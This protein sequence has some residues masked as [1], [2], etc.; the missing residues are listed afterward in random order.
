M[1]LPKRKRSKRSIE[2]DSQQQPQQSIRNENDSYLS[3][4]DELVIAVKGRIKQDEVSKYSLTDIKV[5]E[6]LLTIIHRQQQEAL[7]MPSAESLAESV[8]I[9][10]SGRG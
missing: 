5:S 7:P 9:L 3:S 1:A 10:A 8:L 6:Y 4:L 2:N